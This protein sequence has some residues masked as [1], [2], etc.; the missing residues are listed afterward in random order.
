MLAETGGPH[1]GAYA[2]LDLPPGPDLAG[3]L[4][5]VSPTPA[6]RGASGSER[7]EPGRHARELVEGGPVVG[8]KHRSAGSQRGGRDD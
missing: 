1:A 4:A 5:C 2:D 6:P 3:A 7:H 8:G